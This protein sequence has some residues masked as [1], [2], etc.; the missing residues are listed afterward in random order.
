M[1]IQNYAPPIPPRRSIGDGVSP[2]QSTSHVI[3]RCPIHADNFLTVLCTDCVAPLCNQCLRIPDHHGQ[4]TLSHFN[5]DTSV[6]REQVTLSVVR[7]TDDLVTSV[8]SLRRALIKKRD[9]MIKKKNE[10]LTEIER[11][12][13]RLRAKINAKLKR[14]E[15]RLIDTLEDSVTEQELLISKSVNECETILNT[16]REKSAAVLSQSS[17]LTDMESIKNIVNTKKEIDGFKT[18]KTN[19]EGTRDAFL[20]IRFFVNSDTEQ[21]ILGCSPACVEVLNSRSNNE[22]EVNLESERIQEVS[23]MQASPNDSDVTSDVSTVDTDNES[24]A[25]IT[26]SVSDEPRTSVISRDLN[27][28]TSEQNRHRRESS[29]SSSGVPVRTSNRSSNNSSR[30]STPDNLLSSSM[31]TSRPTTPETRSERRSSM[32]AIRSSTPNPPG[33]NTEQLSDGSESPEPTTHEANPP[34]T[35]QRQTNSFPSESENITS[36]TFDEDEP[37]PPYPGLPTQ[38][39]PDELP[40]PYPG[41]PPP[42]YAQNPEPQQPSTS[43]PRSR[44]FGESGGRAQAASPVPNEIL[45]S[46]SRTS[47]PDNQSEPNVVSVKQLKS[48]SISELSDR[49]SSSISAMAVFNGRYFLVIDRWNKKLKYFSARGESFGGLIF[50]EEPWDIAEITTDLFAVTV[51]KL[52]SIYK[53]QGT[54]DQVIAKSTV[55]TERRYACV[56][57]Q[58]Q[59]E[60]FVCGQV[61]QFGEPVIDVI[62]INGGPVLLTFR[63]TIQGQE[64]FSYPRYVQVSDDSTVVV[65]DWNL[66]C[67][68]FFKSDGT[69]VARYKG[70]TEFPLQEPTGITLNREINKVFVIDSKRDSTQG[71]IHRVSMEGLCEHVYQRQ[72]D[73]RDSRAISSYG[74]RISTGSK[75]GIINTY[76]TNSIR[77]AR[78]Q[79]PPTVP[80]TSL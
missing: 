42:P 7:Q 11:Y 3:G 44:L 4:C 76:T 23:M 72:D 28:D 29:F 25:A 67:V 77:G 31:S 32:P 63:T 78:Q 66:K 39:G 45:L 60:V 35:E 37:P 18:Q 51:P 10:T 13:E 70:T 69:I 56:T 6:L 30:A 14:D 55:I 59:N 20:V 2:V 47:S 15:S 21:N 50:R 41:P 22:H 26:F 71:V 17:G 38:P 74:N 52:N 62:G 75:S 34:T 36:A 64:L 68:V 53:I 54:G 1:S 33:D 58:S 27:L 80:P 19:I 48:F 73:F 43:R 65:C 5:D 9:R 24:S 57:Y 46:P 40:P 49:R 12:F 79:L 61:P 8:K 16:A